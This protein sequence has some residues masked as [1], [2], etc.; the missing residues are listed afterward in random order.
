MSK[1]KVENQSENNQKKEDEKE[2]QAPKN[3]ENTTDDTKPVD[4]DKPLAKAGK[5][6][7]KAIKEAEE[8][9]DKEARKAKSAQ[10]EDEK[11]VKKAPV[12]K[13]R[14]KLERRS[15]NYR[16]SAKKID[17]NKYYNLSDAIALAAQTSTV[18][19]DASVEIHLNL[20]ADPKL[21]DQNIRGSLVLPH[22]TGKTM[23]VAVFAP[24]EEAAALKNAGADIAGE[25]EVINLLSKE[26]LDL[27]ILIAHP[28]LMSQLARFAKLLGPKGLMPNPKSGTVTANLAKAVKEAK[29]GRVEYR[30]DKQ[31]IIHA[32]IGKVSFKQDQ[33][34]ENAKALINSIYSAKPASV[35]GALISSISVT[36]TMG[37]GIKV[38]VSSAK[39]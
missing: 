13:T 1:A 23:R 25:D 32:S 17:S 24:S 37:P 29:G 15:K 27:D 16:N 8:K 38:D 21:A 20:N 35:K 11:S 4:A 30:V 18:K 36:S 28:K 31:G 39:S 5:R 33:L 14:S 7:A 34:V 6:S 19:F 10:T 12:Q 2:K 26:N 3:V 9:A 22:G